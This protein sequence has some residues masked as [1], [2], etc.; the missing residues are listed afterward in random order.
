MLIGD[1]EQKVSV[2]GTVIKTTGLNISRSR[3]QRIASIEF[4]TDVDIIG[5][6]AW[7][8]I[9]SGQPVVVEITVSG[10]PYVLEGEVESVTTGRGNNITQKDVRCVS[11]EVR[12]TRNVLSVDYVDADPEFILADAWAKYGGQA[13]FGFTLGTL[14]DSGVTRL[15]EI[16]FNEQS[17]FEVFERVTAIMDWAWQ[18][19]NGV[20]EVWNPH[21]EPQFAVFD[22]SANDWIRGSLRINEDSSR[23]FNV[24][25]VSGYEYRT[26][27]YIRPVAG[28]SCIRSLYALNWGDPWEF[29]DSEAE[30]QGVGN[31]TVQ[32]RFD[33]GSQRVIYDDENE[34]PA[35]R[36]VITRIRWRRPVLTEVTNAASLATYGARYAPTITDDGGTEIRA[37]RSNAQRFLD[38]RSQPITT[39]SVSLTRFPVEVERKIQLVGFDPDID[40]ELITEGITIDSDTGL[41]ASV[42]IDLVACVNG[43]RQPWTEDTINS[44]CRALNKV[45]RGPFHRSGG[46][47]RTFYSLGIIDLQEFDDTWYHSGEFTTNPVVTTFSNAWGHAGDFEDT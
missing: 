47:G 24:V 22:Q 18:V 45:E 16:S 8:L 38:D 31:T 26:A 27:T 29:V 12:L 6:V 40:I 11:N 44:I 5:S 46:F 3:S 28:N 30:F 1:Y 33:V 23:L 17:L 21:D 25:R 34:S 10:V 15:A 41:D 20:L 37:L 39:A 36:Y 9:V 32:H 2:A 14:P 35:L 13:A 19:R 43:R 7:A 4:Q 42:T